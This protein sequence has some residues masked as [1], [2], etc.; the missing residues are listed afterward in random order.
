MLLK[1]WNDLVVKTLMYFY[2]ILGSNQ[3]ECVH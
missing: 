2:E 3:D 1:F